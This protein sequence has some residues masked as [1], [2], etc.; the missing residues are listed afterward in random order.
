MCSLVCFHWVE[1]DDF[2]DKTDGKEEGRQKDNR[3][4]V[5]RLGEPHAPQNRTSF[6]SRAHGL[7]I[8]SPV[9]GIRAGDWM[10]SLVCFH[11]VEKGCF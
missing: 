10:C 5:L 7:S 6:L 8:L 11:W 4:L 9:A 1:I 2:W 3:R